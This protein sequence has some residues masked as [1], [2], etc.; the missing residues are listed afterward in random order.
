MIT[1]SRP[2]VLSTVQDLG[3]FGQYHIGM[4]PSGAM[5]PFAHR[6]GN[7]LVGNDEDAATIEM[8]YQGGAFEFDEDRVVALCGATMAATI[9]DEPINMWEAVSV[10]AGQ[11]L[12]IQYASNGARSYLAVA[13]GIDVEPLMDSRSTYTLIGLGGYEGRSLEEGDELAL[14]APP[15]GATDRIGSAV[16]DEYIPDYDS[17]DSIRVVFGLCDYRLTDAC[18]E[19][20]TTEPW[21]VTPDADR[22][23]YRLEGPEL[24]FVEREQPFGAGTDQSNVVD[25]G[26]PVGSIQ[27]PQQPIVLMQDAVTGGGYATVGT[28][29]SVDRGYLAQKRT[30]QELYFESVNVDDAVAARKAQQETLAAIRKSLE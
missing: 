19:R 17:I 26:Y 8:T 5:D 30:H 7:Y 14:G 25:L 3:R 10:E 1:V 18:K 22:V 12:D 11:T 16:D 23:G 24:E 4:P 29:I 9:D 21:T 2:G 13:G 27:V 28:V 20:M 6:V 15:E